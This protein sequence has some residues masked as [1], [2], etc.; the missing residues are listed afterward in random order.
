MPNQQ[1]FDYSFGFMGGC[2]DNYSH[3]F[4][5]DGPNRHDLWRN[6][7]EVYASDFMLVDLK[8]ESAKRNNLA[9]KNPGIVLKLKDKYEHWVN[10][11][12]QQ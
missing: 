5:W 12:M 2:I 9:T 7:K 6:G 11:V 4:Y 1:G 3:F 10:T 8:T